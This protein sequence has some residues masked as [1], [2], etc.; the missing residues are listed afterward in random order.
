M[1][2][3]LNHVNEYQNNFGKLSDKY[4]A[5]RKGYPEKLFQY[6]LINA[7]GGSKTLDVGCGTGIASRQLKSH[8]FD[9]IGVDKDQ[10][11]IGVAKISDSKIPYVVASA[12]N[13]PFA[14]DSFDF[15]T[16]FTALH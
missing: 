13:L 1:M 10:V 6:L 5:A 15:V 2:K 9:V 16:T 14:S 11:M 4:V 8:G 7:T 3:R 12:D